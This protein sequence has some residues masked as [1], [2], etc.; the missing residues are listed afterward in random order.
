MID[1]VEAEE[2][3]TMIGQLRRRRRDVSP[4]ANAVQM[5]A[6]NMR[7]FLLS[8]GSDPDRM[9]AP[10][11]SGFPRPIRDIEAGEIHLAGARR[12]P[13]SQIAQAQRDVTAKTFFG[14]FVLLPRSEANQLL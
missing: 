8:R 10:G 6:L 2:A 11:Y 12:Y 4:G 5:A 13:L 9:D 7:S 3:N 14:N 1:T